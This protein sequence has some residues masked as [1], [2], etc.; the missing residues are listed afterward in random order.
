MKA[1]D[2]ETF[3][4]SGCRLRQSRERFYWSNRGGRRERDNVCK[5]CKTDDASKRRKQQRRA[6]YRANLERLRRNGMQLEPHQLGEL[7]G[8]Q[9]HQATSVAR[10]MGFEDVIDSGWE[11]DGGRIRANGKA[12]NAS[13]WWHGEG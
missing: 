8:G 9:P 13:A 3:L 6:D 10:S 4:C 7:W 5:S 1:E 12:S 2:R 11:W